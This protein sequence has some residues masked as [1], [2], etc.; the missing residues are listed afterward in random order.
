L[1]KDSRCAM[2]TSGKKRVSPAKKNQNLALHSGYL[3]AST[4]KV[5]QR[6]S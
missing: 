2:T 5:H 3:S 1:R 6:R 4:Q